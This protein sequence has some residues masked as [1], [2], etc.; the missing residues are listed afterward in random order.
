MVQTPELCPQVALGCKSAAIRRNIS[1]Q[2][3]GESYQI[4][5][6]LTSLQ[7]ILA[8]SRCSLGF[9]S[10]RP[11]AL[12]WFQNMTLTGPSMNLNFDNDSF[13]NRSATSSRPY[14]HLLI[15]ATTFTTF[16]PSTA[17]IVDEGIHHV[18]N[19]A[20]IQTLRTVICRPCSLRL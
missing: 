5:A 11:P 9:S 18:F 1:K 6:R 19:F 8:R 15:F 4:L 12:C 20:T 16:L 3:A 14:S 17:L 13:S 10:G 2:L 7:P